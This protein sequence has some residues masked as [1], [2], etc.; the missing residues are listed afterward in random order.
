MSA[1]IIPFNPF[2]LSDHIY[3]HKLQLSKEWKEDPFVF[4]NL[5]GAEEKEAFYELMDNLYFSLM[6]GGDFNDA[7]YEVKSFIENLQE[8]YADDIAWGGVDGR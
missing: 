4:L 8:E 6:T 2:N 3:D 5:L 7:A 1:V